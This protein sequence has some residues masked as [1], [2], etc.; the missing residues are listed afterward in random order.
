MTTTALRA[1]TVAALSAAVLT[2]SAPAIALADTSPA[3]TGCG[4]EDP[5][6]PGGWVATDCPDNQPLDPEHPEYQP[7][8]DEERIGSYR[9]PD[10]AQVIISVNPDVCG[11]PAGVNQAPAP[12]APSASTARTAPAGPGQ[13]FQAPLADGHVQTDSPAAP[14]TQVGQPFWVLLDK[15]IQMLRAILPTVFGQS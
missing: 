2:V 10:P 7:Q 11:A 14:A 1:L 6:V 8:S 12:A 5:G 13:Q 3:H 9:C 15:L 4:F